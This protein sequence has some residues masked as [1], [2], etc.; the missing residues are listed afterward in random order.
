MHIFYKVHMLYFIQ[1]TFF[2]LSQ[3]KQSICSKDT[4]KGSHG[5]FY[6]LL[7]INP[8]ENIFSTD[9][10][11][12]ARVSHRC[13]SSLR[14]DGIY[15]ES[16]KKK[17]LLA[18]QLHSKEPYSVHGNATF[19]N[20]ALSDYGYQKHLFLPSTNIFSREKVN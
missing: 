3:C 15:V 11:F 8:L 19:T 2:I 18:A 16:R 12:I 5:G 1:F 4:S 17:L 10:S 9:F 14:T 6:C 20:N 13:R 7:I